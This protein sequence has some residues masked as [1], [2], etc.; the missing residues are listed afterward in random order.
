MLALVC[1]VN[2]AEKSVPDR[3]LT[4][5]KSGAVEL[6]LHVF[7]PEDHKASDRRPAIVFFFGGGWHSGTPSQFYEH[8]TYLASR[9]MVAMSAEYRV[10]S[11]NKTTPREC[12]M[13]GKSAVRWIR[14][15]AEELG[16][17]PK[18]VAAGGGSA[19]GHVAAATGTT[20]GFEEEG[21]DLTVSSRPNALVL[22]NPVYDNGPGGFGHARVA[23]YW[24]DFSPMHNISKET[25]PTVVCL[26]TK[27]N[28]I[29][30]KTA[31]E[32]KRLMEAE[33]RRCDLHLH[34]GQPHGFFNYSQRENYT[35]TVIEMDRFLASLGYLKGEPTL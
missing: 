27:D 16:I 3:T 14:N 26:G 31:R 11:R 19:G 20:K 32:Y 18:R 35:K 28:L 1:G 30:V 34:E 8:C 23:G 33:G 13:D 5:K 7:S 10:K 25:P 2:A 17:D 12:V 29:P 9:G 24:K 15:H 6:K 21:E 4:Y 22:F